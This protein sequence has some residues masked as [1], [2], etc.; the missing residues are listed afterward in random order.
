M[1]ILARDHSFSCTT[2]VC[3]IELRSSEV[4]WQLSVPSEPSRQPASRHC[5]LECRVIAV[6]FTSNFS[7]G[8]NFVFDICYVL[9]IEEII[10]FYKIGM[11]YLTKHMGGRNLREILGKTLDSFSITNRA[12][13]LSTN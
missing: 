3:R 1:G 10:R 11:G 7:F 4:W 8:L 12:N 5:S 13:D 6:L 9:G 2:W